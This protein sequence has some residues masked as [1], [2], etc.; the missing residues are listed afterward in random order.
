DALAQAIAATLVTVHTPIGDGI[1]LES[2]RLAVGALPRVVRDGS[3]TDAR[4]AMACA[5][6]LAGLS[7]NLSDCGAEHS[8]GQAL[9]GAFGLPH[10]LTIGLVLAETLDRERRYAPEQLERVADA[11]GLPDDGS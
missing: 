5:S 11:M 6:L 4:S 8:L 10:G 7:M 9:G 1:A 2:I 3:D